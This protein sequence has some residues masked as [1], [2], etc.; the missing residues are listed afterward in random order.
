MTLRFQGIHFDALSWFGAEKLTQDIKVL[1]SGGANIEEKL[2]EA[3]IATPTK[4][5]HGLQPE[6]K[7]LYESLIRREFKR[8][9]LYFIK[10]K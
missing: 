7:M 8:S 1:T 5:I 6:S 2:A 10:S 3:A 9:K 4:L